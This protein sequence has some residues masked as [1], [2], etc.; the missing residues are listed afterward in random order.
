MSE[1]P[2]NGAHTVRRGETLLSIAKGHNVTLSE[3]LAANPEITDPNLIRVGQTLNIPARAAAPAAVTPA[4]TAPPPPVALPVLTPVA[5]EGAAAAGGDPNAI[6]AQYQPKGASDK[7]AQQDKLPQRGI[8]GVRASEEMAKT[9]RKRVI[10]HKAKFIAAGRLFDLPP[11]LL[12]AIAS[13]ESR[14]GAVL[15]N[16]FGDGGHGFGL[17]Q[18]DNRNP[19][20]VVRDGGPAGQPH[21]NQAT[22]ILRDKLDAVRRTLKSLT[23]AEQL[24]TAVSRY[25]GGNGLPPP[26]SDRGT[27]GGDYMNDVWARAQFYARVEEWGAV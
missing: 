11:A 19:F 17:M 12:A 23:P 15:V 2:S 25:N 6:L 26:D 24:Q 8:T 13:R 27:T 1:N 16:G 22:K 10:Q 14:G 5:D 3:L 7:T 9:D 21:I 18:V 4:V 20:P